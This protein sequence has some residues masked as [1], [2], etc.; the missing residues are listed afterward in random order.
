MVVY[1]DDGGSDVVL[2][3]HSGRGME[4]YAWEQALKGFFL[5]YGGV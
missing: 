3:L 2:L 1:D 5:V 4:W